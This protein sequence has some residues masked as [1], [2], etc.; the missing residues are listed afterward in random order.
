LADFEPLIWLRP[1]PAR[2]FA[3]AAV[4]L[5]PSDIKTALRDQIIE[6]AAIV[7]QIEDAIASVEIEIGAVQLVAMGQAAGEISLCQLGLP[8][9]CLDLANTVRVLGMEWVADQQG[10][11]SRPESYA[12]IIHIGNGRFT[13]PPNC[14]FSG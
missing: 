14:R 11:Q 5:V 4:A 12:F 2:W 3:V 6:R 7:L 8:D 10:E 9:L 1:Q 13:T